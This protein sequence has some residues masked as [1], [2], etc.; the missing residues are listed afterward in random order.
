[1]NT[2]SL[3]STCK[4]LRVKLPNITGV[5]MC[6]LA[7]DTYD[8]KNVLVLTNKTMGSEAELLKKERLKVI[9][10]TGS[11]KRGYK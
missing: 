10:G 2:N 7:Y 4:F 5:N 11:L 3:W 8:T 9:K 1:M 6:I